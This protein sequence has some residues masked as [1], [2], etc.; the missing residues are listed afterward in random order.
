MTVIIAG[1]VYVDPADRDRLVEGFRIIVERA[2]EHPGCLDVSISPD[3]IEPGRVNVFEYWES[4]E[5]L[6]AWRAK[7]PHPTAKG[8]L[9]TGRVHKHLVTWTGAPFAQSSA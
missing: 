4:E 3:S 6:T 5:A 7:A 9:E 1:P 8:R 2:R